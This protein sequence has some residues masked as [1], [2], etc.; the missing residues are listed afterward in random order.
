MLETKMIKT[1]AQ[2]CRSS[3]LLI[4]VF[5]AGGFVL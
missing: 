1:A 5:V 2:A 3:G 4:C